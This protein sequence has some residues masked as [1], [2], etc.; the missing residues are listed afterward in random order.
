M[1]IYKSADLLHLELQKLRS[2]GN[3]IGFVPTMGALHAGHRSLLERARA[4]NDTVVCSIFVNPTQFDDKADLDKYPSTIDSDMEMLRSLNIDYLYYPEVQD[5]YPDGVA[6][7]DIDLAGL[8]TIHEGALRPGHF[9]GVAQVVKRFFEIVQPSRAY[10]GQ[11]DFQQTAV[12][13]QLIKVCGFDTKMVV[14]PIIREPHG[15]AMSSRNERLSPVEREKA[16]FIYKSLLKLK[17]RCFFKP[18]AEALATTV[19][20]LE[21]IEDANLEHL[22]CVDGNS[23]Q[24][25]SDLLDSDY[26]VA[27][28]VVKYGG[29]RLLDNIIL[30]K[31][32]ASN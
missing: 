10:F 32:K 11:K 28:T 2:Q 9:Q 1:F 19:E 23:L 7:N 13:S 3:Q 24:E 6:S 31:P 16:S 8:D 14:C 15:L 30:K 4:E 21:S 5:V 18:L 29:V 27:L 20:Y 17:E 26:V 22:I 25:V 12:I